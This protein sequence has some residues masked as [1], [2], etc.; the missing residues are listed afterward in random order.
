[1][2]TFL[3]LFL[4]L[5][6]VVPFVSLS[7]ATT[8]DKITIIPFEYKDF[9]NTSAPTFDVAMQMDCRTNRI[10]ADV[11]SEGQPVPSVMTFLK[12]VQY[13]NPLLSTQTTDSSGHA[14]YQ[15]TG[16]VSFRTGIFVLVMEKSGY[17]KREAHFTINDCFKNITQT[18]PPVQ[19]VTPTQNV[20]PSA[21]TTTP[22]NSTPPA[23]VTP[24]SNATVSANTTQNLTQNLTGNGTQGTGNGTPETGNPPLSPCPPALII[25]AVIIMGIYYPYNL[26]KG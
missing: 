6:S 4:I 15:L 8:P 10:T 11:S 24:S 19:N 17:N 2:R 25:L 9:G 20:T 18:Q 12:Y 23:N 5:L 7:F 16:N 14:T 22:A 26:R 3:L 1:M 13:D 21:N